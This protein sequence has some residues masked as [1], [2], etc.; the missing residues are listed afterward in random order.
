MAIAYFKRW[1]IPL[2]C[3]VALATWALFN[4]WSLEDYMIPSCDE[5]FYSSIS[6]TMLT[7]GR[8][9]LP[10]F[11]NLFGFETSYIG[12][13]R[14]VVFGQAIVQLF[15]GPT[16]F[17]ARLFSLLGASVLIGSAFALASLLY[18]R[19][20]AVWVALLTAA[21]WAVFMQSHYGR[22][23]IWLSAAT[24]FDLYLVFRLARQSSSKQVFVTGFFVALLPDIHLNGIHSIIGLTAVAAYLLLVE[25]RSWRR[26]ILYGLGGGLGAAYF[27]VTHLFPDPALAISQYQLY[28]RPV[29]S[30]YSTPPL[31]E[32]LASLAIWLFDHYITNFSGLSII[33]ALVYLPGIALSVVQPERK[34][35]LLV[36][37]FIVTSLAS[38]SVTGVKLDYYAVIWR[39]VMILLGVAGLL[40][41][42]NHPRLVERLPMILK[43]RLS[44]GLLGGLL[45]VLI[46]GNVYLAG[47]F[48]NTN[49]AA[50]IADLRQF[51]PSGS[52]VMA[53]EYLWYGFSD[54]QFTTTIY[55]L[56][57]YS[58][59]K[60]KIPF[61]DFLR[62][63]IVDVAP[64]YIVL[65]SG[66]GCINSASDMSKVYIELISQLCR[67]VGLVFG[68][69]FN[70][71]TVYQ[72]ELR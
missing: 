47:K 63:Q 61:R 54:P 40:W 34:A 44:Y 24:V 39:P 57:L 27:V 59:L 67:P 50:Y 68:A 72:C 12:S 45:G 20:V 4:F 58:L 65:D 71:S 36:L 14:L 28:F 13:G 41:V 35:S 55:P 30:A 69:W 70:T 8:F 62:Q 60:H 11:N 29:Y 10:M 46:A 37:L 23:D 7:T 66:V 16:L 52:R 32:R 25:A 26:F 15:F 42:F 22:P 5:A 48:S 56:W 1:F 53:D 21:D 43:G 64:D 33:L 51:I 9:G 38:F 18:N 6:Y 19:R 17:S 31:L 49:Y 3:I 2:M